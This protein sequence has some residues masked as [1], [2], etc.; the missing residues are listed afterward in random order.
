MQSARNSSGRPKPV[1]AVQ[2]PLQPKADEIDYEAVVAFARA[3][4]ALQGIELRRSGADG[5]LDAGIAALGLVIEAID[6]DLLSFESNAAGPLRRLHS[7]LYDRSRGAKPTLLNPAKKVS[8][9][10]GTTSDTFR[11]IFAA[12]LDIFIQADVPQS[13]AASLI[14]WKMQARRVQIAGVSTLSGERLRRW[15]HDYP[16]QTN[17]VFNEVFKSF[18]HY[19]M[20][21]VGPRP[22]RKQAEQVL[23]AA[24]LE[25]KRR[26]ACKDSV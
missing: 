21:M 12:T 18:K 2:D 7:A 25:A 11:G 5:D 1:A 9:P 20:S 22:T 17:Q 4:Q 8:K 15:R 16:T 14:V 26:G 24:L 13:E 19:A 10:T 23:E 3:L 6:A